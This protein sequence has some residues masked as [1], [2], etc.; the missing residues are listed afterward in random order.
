[1]AYTINDAQLKLAYR[2]GETAIP[3]SS[4]EQAKRFTWI[5]D[6]IRE[7]L[8]KKPLWFMRKVWVYSSVAG[9]S[10]YKLD[11]DFRRET[12]VY[13]GKVKYEK[14]TRYELDS[15]YNGIV[16]EVFNDENNSIVYSKLGGF[17][18]LIDN[19]T[20]EFIPAPSTTPSSKSV[21]NLVVVSGAICQATVANHGYSAGDYI[22]ISG[23][24]Q[25]QYNGTYSIFDVTTDTFKYIASSPPSVSPA[26]GTITA[27]LRNIKIYGYC[28]LSLPTTGSDSIVIPDEYI[29]AVVAYAEARFWS[30]AHM[31]AKAADAFAEY[32]SVLNDMFREDF[33]RSFKT[34]VY[35]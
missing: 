24:N 20:I 3:S 15:K 29:N 6:A 31:R 17:F 28:K 27:L 18:Y 23:A 19:D 9:L 26:T 33:R 13:I 8:S 10:K 1:M 22:T 5:V 35:R 4:V 21:S 32:E 34:G 14:L 2:L 30:A 7:I 16:S 11:S 25:T 12:D